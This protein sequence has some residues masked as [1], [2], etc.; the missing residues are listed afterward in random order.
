MQ[1]GCWCSPQA[2]LL[3]LGLVKA[4]SDKEE[5]PQLLTTV[6]PLLSFTAPPC[7]TALA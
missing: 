3:R 4:I 1:V 2:E 6:C 5:P 7:C